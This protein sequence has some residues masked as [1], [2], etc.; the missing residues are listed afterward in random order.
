[1]GLMYFNGRLAKEDPR[2]NPEIKHNVHSMMF[3][4]R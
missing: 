2:S 1:L 4:D 3:I